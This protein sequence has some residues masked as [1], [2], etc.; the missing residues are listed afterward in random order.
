[1]RQVHVMFQES[2]S[3]K[4]LKKLTLLPQRKIFQAGQVSGCGFS[5]SEMDAAKH[6]FADLATHTHPMAHRKRSTQYVKP[7]YGINL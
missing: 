3:W 5:R 2:A 6:R 7:R 4:L 1:M